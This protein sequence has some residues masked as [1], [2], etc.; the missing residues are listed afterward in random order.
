MNNF[1][2]SVQIRYSGKT[3]FVVC[4]EKLFCIGNAI[5]SIAEAEAEIQWQKHVDAGDYEK[6]ETVSMR[7]A[8]PVSLTSSINKALHPAVKGL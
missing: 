5:K 4:K 7:D 2:Q 3:W 8:K 6:V 1:K